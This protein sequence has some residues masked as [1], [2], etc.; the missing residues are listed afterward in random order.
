MVVDCKNFSLKYKLNGMDMGVA[1][2]SF[3]KLF[4]C[5]MHDRYYVIVSVRNNTN[6]ITLMN[7]YQFRDEKKQ[8]IDRNDQ[9]WKS[10]FK[11]FGR[12]AKKNEI[13]RNKLKKMDISESVRSDDEIVELKKKLEEQTKISTTLKM[14]LQAAMSQNNKNKK[15]ISKMKIEMMENQKEIDLSR[16]VMHE[17]KK[18][19]IHKLHELE[20]NLLGSLQNVQKAIASQYENKYDCR[21]CMVNEKDIVLIPCGHFLCSQCIHKVNECPMCRAKIEKT[22]KLN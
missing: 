14:R 5:G 15:V 18:L 22:I 8:K 3:D 7:A 21:V 6:S 11:P 13:G 12:K 20:S 1:V 2:R 17:L 16:G 4:G 10:F 9:K 19:S